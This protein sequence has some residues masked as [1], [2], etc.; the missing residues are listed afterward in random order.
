[1]RSAANMMC[2]RGGAVAGMTRHMFF[3]FYSNCDGALPGL[4][5]LRKQH[6]LHI[7]I[8]NIAQTESQRKGTLAS[9][10]KEAGAR[11]PLQPPPPP[12]CTPLV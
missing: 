6:T 4:G 12:L 8:V 5:A 2:E 1:M 11:A 7:N 3:F 10:L 9:D